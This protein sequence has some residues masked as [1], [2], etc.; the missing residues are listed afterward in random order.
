MT[1]IHSP[2]I[3]GIIQA[4]MGSR[5]LPGK[6]L[7]ELGGKTILEWVLLRT[8]SCKS[9][10]Q[11]VLATSVR[12]IDDPLISIAEKHHISTFRG[13][14]NDVLDRFSRAAKI[15]SADYI[16]RICADNPFIDSNE[17]DLL[18]NFF[19]KNNCDYSC[20]HQNKLV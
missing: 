4:R 20:N 13:S 6:M 3:V 16:I 15:N 18:I 7:E 10:D 11:I 1:V 12:D 8:K 14:E 2:K 9:L 19:S 17:I 5:R